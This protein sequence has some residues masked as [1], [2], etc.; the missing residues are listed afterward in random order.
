MPFKPQ[1]ARGRGATSSYPQEVTETAANLADFQNKTPCAYR[2]IFLN[3]P[4]QPTTCGRMHVT[5]FSSPERASK[6]KDRKG[7]GRY[8]DIFCTELVPHRTVTFVY[9]YTPSRQQGKRLLGRKTT[10]TTT[11]VKQGS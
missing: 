9:H 6:N 4:Q 1:K 11:T 7:E 2:F 5:V 10:T 3:H 8:G